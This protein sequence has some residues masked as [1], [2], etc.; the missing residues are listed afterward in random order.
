MRAS[1]MAGVAAL[2]L[3]Y[4]ACSKKEPPAKVLTPVK[5]TAV[6]MADATGEMR[7]SA[8]LVPETKVDLA[9]R[10]SGYVTELHQVRDGNRLRG[11]DAGDMVTRGTVLARVR[12]EDYDV[13]VREARSTLEQSIAS[14]AA[15][16]SQLAAAEASLKQAEIDHGRASK[17]F[18]SESLTKSDYDN[19]VT[20]LD[21][22][23]AQADTARNQV[24]ATQRAVRT[25]EAQLHEAEI[26]FRD[27]D[28]RAPMDGTVLARTMEVGTLVSPGIIGVSLGDIG[29]LKAVFGV[30]D[31]VVGRLQIGQVLDVHT[32]A[33]P[34][35]EFRGRITLISPAADSK[36]RL[37]DVELSVPNP[38][39]RLRPGMI[40]TVAVA[41]TG[42]P[43]QALVVPLTAIAASKTPGR[44]AVYLLESKDNGYVA[45]IR[46]V[47]LGEARGNAIT[48]LEG[49]SVGQQVI[50]EGSSM[51]I[52]G[53]AVQ[54]V[55]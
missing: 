50:T 28:L 31:A 19:A 25:A 51:V 34:R 54:L 15:A 42:A 18:Q 11:V 22:A 5:A 4:A 43:G 7:Y 37:F 35:E 46:D 10:V 21:V 9:F 55:P 47:R 26:P 38:T 3:V 6:Q 48:I 32:D 14:L 1:Q 20:K 39:R 41:Q 33:F 24:D 53:Q 8:T 36:S 16:K 23:K 44:Y 12:K 49:V 17:L 30:P 29:V 45:R 52:D 27:T 13:K 40:A 2:A